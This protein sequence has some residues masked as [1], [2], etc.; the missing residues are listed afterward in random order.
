MHEPCLCRSIGRCGEMGVTL[1]IPPE[2]AAWRGRR[3]PRA[4]SGPGVG[5]ETLRS[6]GRF[7]TYRCRTVS[8]EGHLWAAAQLICRCCGS[9]QTL[10]KTVQHCHGAPGIMNAMMHFAASRI[11]DLLIAGA[12]LT[13]HAGPF[14]EN[15]RESTPSAANPKFAS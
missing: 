10:M 14:S 7:A 11:N 6:R 2:S 4:S 8:T 9:V 5:H 15:N 13:W 1:D 12:E 3:R